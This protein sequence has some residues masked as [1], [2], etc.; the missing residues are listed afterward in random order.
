MVQN[1]L[2]E[3]LEINDILSL[4]CT[5]LNKINILCKV[6]TYWCITS[7]NILSI[8]PCSPYRI[9]NSSEKMRFY[10][11]MLKIKWCSYK[12]KKHMKKAYREPQCKDRLLKSCKYPPFIIHI[13]EI[14]WKIFSKIK[15]PVLMYY[16]FF[17]RTCYL[18]KQIKKT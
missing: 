11:D 13:P 3:I 8:S 15:K 14:G 17:C 2:T 7:H 18:K 16:N 1:A 9:S 4:W 12:V 6:L 5:D 10:Y